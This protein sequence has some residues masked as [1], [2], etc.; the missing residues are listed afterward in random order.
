MLSREWKKVITDHLLDRTK[1]P[2]VISISQS[3]KWPVDVARI[4]YQTFQVKIK[5]ESGVHNFI[6]KVSEPGT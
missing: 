5:D 2:G 4:D 1:I 6:V 3:A